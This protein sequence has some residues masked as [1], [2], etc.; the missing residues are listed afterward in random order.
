MKAA[1]TIRELSRAHIAKKQEI[2]KLQ[3]ELREVEFD[4]TAALIDC[5]R[6]DL[7][8]VNWSRVS[9]ELNRGNLE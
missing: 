7:M 2:A 5:G 6:I 9:S 3:G 4:M 8:Q 1:K